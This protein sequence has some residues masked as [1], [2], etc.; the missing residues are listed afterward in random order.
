MEE[1][2]NLPQKE[3]NEFDSE[4]ENPNLLETE[5]KINRSLN[6]CSY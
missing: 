3:K 4:N 2:N 5:E 6:Q 1:L